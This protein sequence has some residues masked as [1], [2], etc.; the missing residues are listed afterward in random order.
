M[1]ILLLIVSVVFISCGHSYYVVRHAERAI[2]GANMSSDVPLSDAGRQR[3]DTLRTILKNKKI[4]EV[5]S[6]NTNRTRSTAQP[7]ADHF[8]LTISNYGPRPDSVFIRLLKSKRKNILIVGHSNTVDELV[9]MLAGKTVVPGDLAESEYD[10]LF[11]IKMK[12][13]KALFERTKYGLP[14]K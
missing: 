5:Y 9:N 14:S 7:T 10:N 1:R 2:Q 3:A 11:I 12:G 4:A 8:G 6:T 13:R